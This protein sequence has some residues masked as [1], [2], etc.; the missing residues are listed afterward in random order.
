MGP[1]GF[2]RT[3]GSTNERFVTSQKSERLIYTAAEAWNCA[4]K[5]F[6]AYAGDY[7]GFVTWLMCD[8]ADLAAYGVSDEIGMITNS[9][10][11]DF[12][13]K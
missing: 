6:P 1:I 9:D 13:F 12:K 8:N 7:F 4:L 2:P 3:S 11:G 5:Y 10:W